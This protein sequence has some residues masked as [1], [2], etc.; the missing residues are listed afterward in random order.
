MLKMG[1]KVVKKNNRYIVSDKQAI[2][3]KVSEI[4]KY[5]V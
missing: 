3:P 1:F 4:H 5:I 2:S